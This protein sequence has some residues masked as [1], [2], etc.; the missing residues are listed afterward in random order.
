MGITITK[1]K[2]EKKVAPQQLDTVGVA[3]LSVEDLADRYGTL[4][5]KVEALQHNPVYVQFA[6]VQKELAKRLEEYEPDVKLELK[7]N[8]WILDIGASARKARSLKEG[9]ISKIIG[10]L[11]MQ[12]FAEI[13]KV[14]ISDCEKYLTPDQ[15]E[16][17]IE[18]DNG[19]TK[20]RKITPKFLG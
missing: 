5:D 17:V 14:T 1:Q 2:E 4:F 13:A 12:T 10:F 11:G 18:S 15:V 9:A 16:E 6:E 7:G 19:Y 8:H 20:N 3:E